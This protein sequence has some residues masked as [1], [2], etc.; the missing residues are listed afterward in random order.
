MEK[1]DNF[2]GKWA[3]RKLVVFIIATILMFAGKLESTDWTY[4]AIAY[5]A[6]QG[7]VDVTT[8]MDKYFKK[9]N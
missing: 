3:S 2:L 5:I 9:Q 7:F 4:L 8:L 1:A 6:M